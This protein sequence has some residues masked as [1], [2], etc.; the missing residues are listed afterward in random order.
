MVLDLD[1]G[2]Q[3]FA[4]V[5]EKVTDVRLHELRGAGAAGGSAGALIAYCGA[6]L[7]SGIDVVLGTMD[8]AKHLSS[9]DFIVTG[10]GKTDRQTL[11]GKAL[12]GIA[13]LAKVEDVP[14][15]VISGAIEEA[16]REDLLGWF[17]EL[18][19]LDDGEKSLDELM[20]NAVQLLENKVSAVMYS[21]K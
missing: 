10:E 12:M 9:A 14:A 16:A 8:F 3:H 19:A 4:D 17:S 1:E 2:L 21:R 15:V 7:E 11:A 6:R 18:H 13:K 5:T 20:A